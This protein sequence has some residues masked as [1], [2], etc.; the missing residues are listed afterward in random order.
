MPKTSSEY[1]FSESPHKPA[2]VV[3]D[4]VKDF[5]IKHNRSFKET[6]TSL[7]N[8]Q[9]SK[10][11]YRALNGISFEVAPGESLAVLGRNGSGKSTTLK[12]ISGVQ[13]PDGGW[14]RTRGRVGGLLEVGAGFHP[15]LSGRDNIY[16]NSAILGMSKDETD[17]RYDEIVEFSGISNDFLDSEVK[18]YSS[19]MKSRLGFAVAVHTEVDVLLVDEV[20][21]VGDAAFKAKCND[22]ILEMRDQGKTMFIV[23]H[24]FGTVRK[25]CERGVVLQDGKV[26]FDGPIDEAVELIKPPKQESRTSAA[27]V[28]KPKPA[29]KP[30]LFA[31]PEVFL[32]LL[33]EPDTKLGNP[34]DTATTITANGGGT[35]QW[36]QRG[37]ITH[38]NETGLTQFVRLGRFMAAYAEHGGAA[39][40]WGFVVGRPEGSL[41][42]G[43]RQ[44]LAFQNGFASCTLDGPVEFEP[45]EH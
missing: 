32:P 21:S 13:Q 11:V 15:D 10:T 38:S 22:K 41:E 2:I 37:I 45:H 39:G 12:L 16:L 35:S 36:F 44:S 33:E 1:S 14:V 34:L 31:I 40:P 26:A 43:G 25:L 28:S 23:S 17:A 8:N 18:R 4:V 3:Q 24:S 6:V 9:P 5:K 42:D 30:A 20:L 27:A 19:G 7:F 29:K